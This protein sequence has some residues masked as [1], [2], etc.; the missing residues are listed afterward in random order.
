KS[1][2]FTQ[3]LLPDFM[4]EHPALTA[5]WDVVFDARGHFREPHTRKLIGIGTLEVRE[6]L[7]AWERELAPDVGRLVLRHTLNTVGPSHRYR[8]APFVQREDLMPLLER[9]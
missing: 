5:N 3:T 9:A 8:Y 2:Y 4:R 6:Y 7:A 1:A